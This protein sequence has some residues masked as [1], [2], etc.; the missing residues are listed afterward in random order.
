MSNS[1]LSVSA[2]AGMTLPYG[3]DPRAL[4]AGN[5]LYAY[6]NSV[7]SIPNLISG[8]GQG[9]RVK[10]GDEAATTLEKTSAESTTLR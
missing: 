10:N 5:L 8:Y 7:M 2:L 1:S 4:N 3:M 6:G 9:P